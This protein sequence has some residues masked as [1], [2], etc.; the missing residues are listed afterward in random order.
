[1]PD[2]RTQPSSTA[3]QRKTMLI[4]KAITIIGM[5][6]DMEHQTHLARRSSC[7]VAFEVFVL[8]INGLANGEKR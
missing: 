4:A 2:P 6:G 3:I 7:R 8:P 5:N 1:M